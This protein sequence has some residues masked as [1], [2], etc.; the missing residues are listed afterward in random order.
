MT[1][2]LT[3]VKYSGGLIALVGV[4]CIILAPFIGERIFD[5]LW[6]VEPLIYIGG[7]LLI[8]GLGVSAASY[9]GAEWY[10]RRSGHGTHYVIF[11]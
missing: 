8:A 11:C 5:F 3:P 9:A 1:R 2:L 7:A 4:V 10:R 6:G